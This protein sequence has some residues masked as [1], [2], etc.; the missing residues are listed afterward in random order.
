MGNPPTGYA[1]YLQ[2]YDLIIAAFGAFL[3]IFATGLWLV[4][5]Y[6]SPVP[7]WDEWDGEYAHVFRPF[8]DGTLTLND[9]LATQNEHRILLTKLIALA[10]LKI[11]G[12]WDVIAQMELNAAIHAATLV[13]IGLW[14]AKTASKRYG[15]EAS[16][17]LMMFIAVAGAIPFG[18]DN[19][20]MGFNTH[21]Y[22]YIALSIG[23]INLL[24]G[25][26]AFSPQWWAGVL[27]GVISLFTLAGGALSLCPPLCV[28][29]LQMLRG[30]RRGTK[31]IVGI[32][33][34]AALT[35]LLVTTVPAV[36]SSAP[37]RARSVGQFLDC[38][39][40]VS[41]WP[42]PPQRFFITQGVPFLAF[43][44]IVGTAPCRSDRR[45]RLVGGLAWLGMQMA[46]VAYSRAAA[47]LES[48]YT[49]FW[50]A[51]QVVG[52]AAAMSLLYEKRFGW[53]GRWPLFLA[54]GGWFLILLKN[55]VSTARHQLPEAIHTRWFKSLLQES[56]LRD[57]LATGNPEALSDHQWMHLP[58][59][60]PV[61]L[62]HY[63]DEPHVRA[64]LPRAVGGSAQESWLAHADA[65]FIAAAQPLFLLGAIMLFGVILIS[66]RR[67]LINRSPLVRVN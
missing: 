64:I 23:C 40:A 14:L 65:G 22:L 16:L 15:H 35:A 26:T 54:V 8:L 4:G 37:Y 32:C 43:V 5:R 38:L 36:A 39:K 7:F 46:L 52:S 55:F 67:L 57:Y 49:D 60:D 13:M 29:A 58:Y 51:G 28:M 44:T 6:G 20:L 9:L 1:S 24:V 50:I 34:L 41:A 17:L 11:G 30:Q 25:A 19:T 59:P 42:L 45:W 12:R 47:P 56:Y 10:I 66:A 53:F 21:F 27:V 18:W 63:L 62:R 61:Q 3:I 31:E 33:A 48:R 2:R